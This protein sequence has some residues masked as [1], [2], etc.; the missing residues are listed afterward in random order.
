VNWRAGE[1][2]T[3][4]SWYIVTDSRYNLLAAMSPA[5]ATTP[6]HL[7]D[8][9]IRKEAATTTRRHRTAVSDCYGCNICSLCYER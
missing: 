7:I 6:W 1:A 2:V 8:A 3:T 5:T 9:A 4:V